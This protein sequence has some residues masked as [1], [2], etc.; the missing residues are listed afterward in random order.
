MSRGRFSCRVLLSAVSLLLS[1]SVSHA[2][3]AAARHERLETTVIALRD[4]LVRV[5][6][7][8]G[9]DRVEAVREIDRLLA[10]SRQDSVRAAVRLDEAYVL[11]KRELGSLRRA[12]PP[13]R[14]NLLN[15]IRTSSSPSATAMSS[16]TS[17]PLVI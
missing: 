2:Q 15:K 10:E 4:A 8:R 5:A 14:L 1:V 6:G 13:L 12:D 17:W 11:V 7:G 3:D 16:G 9:V